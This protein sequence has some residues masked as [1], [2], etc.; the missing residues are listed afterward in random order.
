[1][2][3][4]S[5]KRP[6]V[7]FDLET[8]GADRNSDRIVQFCFLSI[9][10]DGSREEL[11]K[12]VKPLVKIS[13][14]AIAV[15]GITEQAVSRCN[16][17]Q[18]YAHS[19]LQMVSDCDLVGFGILQFDVPLLFNELHRCGHTWDYTRCNIIDACNIYKRHTP[20]DLASAFKHYCQ[21]TMDKAHDAHSDTMATHEVF[22]AQIVKHG[23][24]WEDMRGLALYS[25]YDKP[26]VDLSGKFS[27][28]DHGEVLLNI[29]QN[30]G[31]K[32]KDNITFLRW[33]LEKD[34]SEDTKII[35]R[36]II[37]ENEIADPNPVPE[38]PF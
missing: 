30:R 37:R 12:Y 3:N 35:C 36:K 6:L 25:N 17:F 26:L 8:T 19:V 38:L 20:R 16:A 10:P 31:Q 24:N 15:H 13:E 2:E 9:L 29:G 1:M 7:F 14:S 27:V 11:T 18:Y 23:L 4:I 33:M 32:A 28:D 21:G 22:S 5:L 34:F